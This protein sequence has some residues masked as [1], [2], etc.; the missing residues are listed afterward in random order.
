MTAPES[1]HLRIAWLEYCQAREA[2]QIDRDRVLL[3][4]AA[5]DPLAGQERKEFIGSCVVSAVREYERRL[6]VARARWDAAVNGA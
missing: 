3:A 6:D 1:P 2:A 5:E 4:L